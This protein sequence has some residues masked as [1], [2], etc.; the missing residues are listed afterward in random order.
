MLQSAVFG[1]RTYFNLSAV[2]VILL[3]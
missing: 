3:A 1:R 2:T